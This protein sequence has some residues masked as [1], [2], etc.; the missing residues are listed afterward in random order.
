MRG[1][2][3][4]DEIQESEVVIL[5]ACQSIDAEKFIASW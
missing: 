1:E 5:N 2:L 4:T 3:H